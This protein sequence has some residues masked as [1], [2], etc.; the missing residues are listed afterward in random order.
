MLARVTVVGHDG[1]RTQELAPLDFTYTA[2]RPERQ[3]FRP[4]EAPGGALPPVSLADASTDTVDLVGDGLPDIVQLNGSARFWRNRGA[5]RYVR[6]EELPQ[7]PAGID[8]GDPGV[9]MADM[10]GNGRA[11][12]LTL[13]LQGYFRLGTGPRGSGAAFVPYPT[14]PSVSFGADDIRLVDLDGDGVVDALRTATELELFFNDPERGWDR[15]ETRP[16]RPLAEFPDVDFADPR[17]KLADL[18]GDGLQDIVLVDQGRIDYW[19]YLGHGRWGRRVTMADS[20]RFRDDPPLPEGF[21]P[22][23][24]LLGDL[25]GDGVADL[26]YVQADRVTV[27][28]NQGG[29]RW[30]A[31]FHFEGTPPFTDIDGVRLIDMLGIGM[32]GVL[33]TSDPVPGTG[34]HYRFLDL[35][36]GLKPYLLATTDNH[37]GAVTKVSYASSTGFYVDD[38][39]D[40]STRWRTKLPFPTHVVE[41]VEVI[42]EVSAGRLTRE[43]HYRDGYWD[44]V[45]REFRGFGLVEQYDTETFE[46]GGSGLDERQFSPPVLTRTWFHLGAVGDAADDPHEPDRADDDWWPEDP[47]L[48]GHRDGVEAFLAT[49]PDRRSRRDAL[50]AL[51]GSV[52]RTELY[53]VDGSTLAARPHV[54]TERAYGLRQES[55]PGGGQAGRRRVFFPHLTAERTSRWERGTEP[56]TTFEFTDDHDAHGQPRRTVRVAVPRG[57]DPL[58]RRAEAGDPY[59]A[60]TT[61]TRVAAGDGSRFIV[62][63][64]AARTTH[65][66]VNDGRPNVFE[67]RDAARTDPDRFPVA[68][69]ALTYYDGEPFTGL[70]LGR[71]GPFGAIVR[72][73]ALVLTDDIVRRS[74]GDDLPPYLHPDGPP[75]WTDDHPEVFRAA[76]PRLAGYR[77]SAGGDG[78]ARGWFAQEARRRYDV[79]AGRSAGRGLVVATRDARGHDTTVDHDRFGLLAVRSTDPAGLV[80]TARHDYR[81]LM[82]DLSSDAN[83]NRTAYRFTPLGLV[84]SMAV[85][86]RQGSAV[87]DTAAAPST[88]FV[89]E[90]KAAP[91]T[92]TAPIRPVSVR[93]IRRVHHARGGGVPPSERDRT[94]ETVECSDGFGRLVQT[95]TIAEDVTFGDPVRGA[96]VVPVGQGDPGTQDDV[97]GR[98]APAAR[99]AVVVSGWQVYDNKG[100]VVE[101]LEPFFA[102]DLAFAPPSAAQE[103]RRLTVRYDPLGRIVRTLNPDGSEERVLFGVP[104]DPGDPGSFWPTPWESFR[105]DAND[106]AAA[107]GHEHHRATPSSAVLDAL[108]RT[109]VT[110]ERTRAP[111][112]SPDAPLPPVTEVVTRTAYDIRGNTVSVTD[113]LGREAL[114]SVHDLA[115]RELRQAGIDAGVRHCVLDA[116]GH[117][118]EERDAKGALTL[119]AYD[120]LGRVSRRWARDDGSSDVTL[121]E[122]LDHG[123]G[124]DARQPVADRAAARAANRLGRLHRHHDEAGLL[125]ADAYDFKGN[126]AEETRQVI[127]DDVLLAASN[128]ADGVFRVDWQPTA[129]ESIADLDRRLLDP[130]PYATSTTY[131]ALD[132]PVTVVVPTGTDGARRRLRYGH[133]RAGALERVALDGID[134]VERIVRDAGGRRTLVALGNGVMT[135]YAHDPRTTRLARLRSERF[136]KPTA[137]VPTYRPTG[138]AI[139]DLAYRYDAAGNVIELVDRTPGS[140]VR[141]NPDAVLEADPDL[142]AAVAR[143]D[144]LVRRFT[145]DP[146]AR[147]VSATGRACTG[148]LPAAPWDAPPGC[149]FDSGNHGTPDQDNAPALA[150]VY[151]EQY[152]YDAAGNL[153]RSHRSTGGSGAARTFALVDGTNRLR[154][155]ESGGQRIDHAY[156]ASGNLTAEAGSRRFG[157]DHADRMTAFR[158]QAGT[159]EPSVHA[160]YLYDAAGNR[161]KK[162]VRR[163]GGARETVTYIGKLF[164]HHVWRDAGGGGSANTAVHVMDGEQRVATV[165]EGPAHPDDR[166]PATQY[167]LGD[168][169][170]HASVTVD[171]TAAFVNREEYTPHGETTFGSFGRKRYRYCGM[172][173]DE[174]SGLALHQHRYLAP[175]LGRWV[176]TDPAG[177]VD[178]PN[179]YALARGNP[180]RFTD[181][182]GTQSQDTQAPVPPV[183]A[184]ARPA[185]K[186]LGKDPK[187]H[188][189][190]DE[191]HTPIDALTFALS[192]PDNP[193]DILS[194]G[195]DGGGMP[196]AGWMI[197]D[198]FLFAGSLAS[199]FT[200]DEPVEQIQAG[201]G[202][203]E[204]S[205][206]AA[207]EAAGLAGAE[208]LSARL[209]IGSSMAGFASAYM[210]IWMDMGESRLKALNMA[211]GEGRS[212]GMLLGFA[213]GTT[214]GDEQWIRN[215]L[216]QRSSAPFAAAKVRQEAFNKALWEGFSAAGQ[217]T[218][219]ERQAY[220]NTVI[221]YAAKNGKTWTGFRDDYKNLVFGLANTTIPALR[222][223]KK[224]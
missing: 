68:G 188:G 108:G 220:V 175:W 67:L 6:P 36:G 183:P 162:L 214:G 92:A 141:A 204:G 212:Q 209:A 136:T 118:V 78:V 142:R 63:R 149:G 27:W 40:P 147:L 184:A 224:R 124:G 182:T 155:V 166:G 28:I 131:D 21:D 30:S 38:E 177:A 54:V 143:G 196:S 2:F 120:V 20:P 90:L 69:Q 208:I 52:L 96:A 10:N 200:S 58:R 18:D 59:L 79:Q 144:A 16:R 111:R 185:A 218:P 128:S 17:V 86:G 202:V 57:R 106:L 93:T 88:R 192:L 186:A 174:E 49:L 4:I 7:L 197:G 113:G 210:F 46:R 55:P 176:S 110:V 114:R 73:E 42:D 135:R 219:E 39:A 44:G 66:V 37:M 213:V 199:L 148:A 25:D 198:K 150:A 134:V 161:V 70:P 45:E 12:L 222:L 138:P 99:P 211:K 84:E 158:T 64:V 15:I 107:P 203:L 22:R 26:V 217:L 127:A 31:P 89:Y 32:C 104:A 62:D 130:T 160:Q 87:G 9:Q 71:L 109:V 19:P 51:R 14:A 194:V 98:Q 56:M 23:R 171:E 146:L 167:I 163:Q 205:L 168:H 60:T 97:A 103:G 94:I 159:A 152:E 122:R 201:L 145:Y 221:D 81:V 82:P 101:K 139:Q 178:G 48:L 223:D 72:S 5:G 129:G 125:T 215:E 76:T 80:T 173:R 119:T 187:L 195:M 29:E 33:W 190:A 164:E 75:A 153:I 100:R 140:G 180:L 137:G 116:A 115:D 47:P 95:R 193:L 43:Y 172:E 1:E 50:R 151:R 191:G 8:L 91:G 132:R 105:Y 157:W 83:G 206:G 74:F 154:R 189:A 133:D 207:S 123:D 77:F 35:T 24:V 102:D 179:L 11:D 53:A 34:S 121:R 181:P 13:P 65:D 126:V 156:D 61:L 112:P 85:L 170:G 3:Q 216:V 165:R 169:L 117:V 41:R